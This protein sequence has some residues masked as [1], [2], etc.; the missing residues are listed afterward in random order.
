MAQYLKTPFKIQLLLTDSPQRKQKFWQ[1][2]NFINKDKR[3]NP[4]NHFFL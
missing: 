3:I 2:Y 4:F 1:K